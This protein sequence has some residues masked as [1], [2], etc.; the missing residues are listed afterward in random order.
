MTSP[1]NPINLVKGRFVQTPTG[2]VVPFM[3][4]PTEVAIDDG[5]EWGQT[6][7]PLRSH[8]FYGGGAGAEESFNFTLFLDGDRGRSDIRRARQLAAVATN[9]F[10]PAA[11]PLDV[12]PEINQIRQFVR[13]HD[14]EQDGSYGVPAKLLINLGTVLNAEVEID[15]TRVIVTEFTP[16]LEALRATVEI[17]GHINSRF[18]STDW[19]F[20]S[21]SASNILTEQPE[22]VPKVPE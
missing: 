1:L 22:I 18:N 19:A 9:T 14:T 5:W 10:V 11:T 2:I 7:M 4:N 12:M 16:K 3:F 6:R 17:Q 21:N 13:P 8:P 20:T 15:S